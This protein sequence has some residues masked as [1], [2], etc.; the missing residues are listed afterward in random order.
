MA[1]LL[2]IAHVA[3]AFAYVPSSGLP[4]D[5][6]QLKPHVSRMSS[7]QAAA[8]PGPRGVQPL[9]TREDRISG[10]ELDFQALLPLLV[11]IL[12]IGA[13]FVFGSIF[14]TIA[15]PVVF[16]LLLAFALLIETNDDGGG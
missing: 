9:Q 10:A 13:A 6:Y 4:N 14:S 15:I 11:Q 2:L 3:T 8:P 16:L 12:P 5:W 1:R 7:I